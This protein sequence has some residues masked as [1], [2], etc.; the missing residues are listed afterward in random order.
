[1][2]PVTY[3]SAECPRTWGIALSSRLR[4]GKLGG[5][6]PLHATLQAIS[7]PIVGCG[8]LAV[9]FDEV[10]RIGIMFRSPG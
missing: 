7:V 10:R 4:R 6:R 5:R 1:M 3:L 8:L 2:R 9:K